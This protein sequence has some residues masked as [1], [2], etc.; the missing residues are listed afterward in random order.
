MST[1]NP[2][3]SRRAAA[4]RK[5]K[6]ASGGE[7]ANPSPSN[8]FVQLSAEN[9]Y[10]VTRPGWLKARAVGVMGLPAL[11]PVGCHTLGRLC[12]SAQEKRGQDTRVYPKTATPMTTTEGAIPRGAAALA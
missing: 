10:P 12:G 4:R 9:R 7:T 2:N 5:K 11:A 3:G 8:N 6:R 1:Q